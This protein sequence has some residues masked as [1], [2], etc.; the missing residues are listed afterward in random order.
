MYLICGIKTTTDLNI[1]LPIRHGNVVNE[2]ILLT[3]GSFRPGPSKYV[4]SN[5]SPTSESI[6]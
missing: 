4:L 6:M 3:L 5:L 2:L 1:S